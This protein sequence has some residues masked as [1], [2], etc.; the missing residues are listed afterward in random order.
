MIRKSLVW[1]MSVLFFSANPVCAQLFEIPESNFEY[2]EG[3]FIEGLKR[4]PPFMPPHAQQS[5]HCRFKIKL[6]KNANID[7]VD[8]YFCTDFL[9]EPA[10]L[11]SI[12]KWEFRP[13]LAGTTVDNVMRFKLSDETGR[14][15]PEPEVTSFDTDNVPNSGNDARLKRLLPPLNLGWE[16]LGA[17]VGHCCATYSIS[18]IGIPFNVDI[19]SCSQPGLELTSKDVIRNWYYEPAT[20]DGKDVSVEGHQ[21][22]IKFSKI[23]D[24]YNVLRDINGLT[25]I[26][27]ISEGALDYCRKLS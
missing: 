26:A 14:L 12:E 22:V 4:V 25:P 13:E 17:E 20:L 2:P 19:D 18:Q 21:G 27:A 15:I 11:E 1:S 5:G 9:F 10:T 16:R 6:D 23:E 8:I 24:R 3:K 7:A